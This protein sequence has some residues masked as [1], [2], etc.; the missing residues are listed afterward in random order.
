MTKS[1][2]AA[3][4]QMTSKGCL[5]TKLTVIASELVNDESNISGPYLQALVTILDG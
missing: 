4:I 3:K 5:K 2:N 1:T